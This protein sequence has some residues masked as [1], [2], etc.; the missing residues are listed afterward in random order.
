MQETPIW[1]EKLHRTGQNAESRVRLAEEAVSCEP[2][3]R[4]HFPANR[5]N[6]RELAELQPVRANMKRGLPRQ[7][8]IAA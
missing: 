8:G 7:I 3:S 2:V 6:Y 5:E 1:R 4:L